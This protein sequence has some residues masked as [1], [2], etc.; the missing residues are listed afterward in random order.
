MWD[1]FETI[2]DWIVYWRSNL[3]FWGGLILVVVVANCIPFE[4][5]RWIVAGCIF[6]AGL[7][8]GARWQWKS[9][10]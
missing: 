6:V 2:L 8:I 1:I 3:C 10:D 9:D 4:P 7:V 5:L